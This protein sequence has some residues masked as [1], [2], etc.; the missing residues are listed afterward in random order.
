MIFQFKLFDILC[1]EV[2]VFF[3]ADLLF[4]LMRRQRESFRAK[5]VTACSTRCDSSAAISPSI[6]VDRPS[7][8]PSDENCQKCRKIPRRINPTRMRIWSRR[9]ALTARPVSAWTGKVWGLRRS[10]RAA[11]D[12]CFAVP[13][14]LLVKVKFYQLWMLSLCRLLISVDCFD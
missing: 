14:R 10:N 2:S 11:R 13:Q 8:E 9:R 3:I 6:P 1:V 7:W 5:S 4:Q 12:P